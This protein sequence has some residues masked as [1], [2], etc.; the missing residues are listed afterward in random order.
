MDGVRHL[1]GFVNER[2]GWKGWVK[3]MGFCGRDCEFGLVESLWGMELRRYIQ[4]S[5]ESGD[6]FSRSSFS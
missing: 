1:S 5:L 2:G 3:G 6:F 4:P